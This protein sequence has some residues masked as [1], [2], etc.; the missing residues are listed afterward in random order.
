MNEPGF[1]AAG[2]GL[3]RGDEIELVIEKLIAGGDG[4]GRHERL[5]VFVPRTAPGDRARVR[6]AERKASYARAEVVEILAPGPGRRAAPCRHFGECG[7]CD[8]QHLEDERQIA[9]KVAATLE[10]LA[11]I[12][13]VE[14]PAHEVVGGAPWG[15][16]T[17]TRLH[18]S[19][20]SDGAPGE[21]ATLGY[22]GRRSHRI[23]AV[24][25][26]PVLVPELERAV[27]E[28]AATPP[29]HPPPRIDLA[30]GDGGE[31]SSAPVARGVPH[32]DVRVAVGP[33]AYAFDARCFFQGNR[34]LLER[35][36]EVAVGD[37]GGELAIDLYAGV[38]LFALPLA[39][40][41]ARVVAVEGDGVAARY[42]RINARRNG[43]GNV[44]VVH[45]AVE[46]WIPELPAACDR[47][48]VD[49][50]RPGLA[51]P[52]LRA[53]VERRPRTLTYVSC[54]P[55]ALARDLRELRTAY[56]IRA[57]TL[58]D[59]FPQTGHIEIVVQLTAMPDAA[60]GDPSP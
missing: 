29:A 24:E 8:L 55:A 50:P 25:E 60:A 32:G 54:H 14:L 41:Y 36:A 3:T 53:L 48:V 18:V 12:G 51:P 38:G 35:L 5:P 30:V 26:C 9:Y 56:E 4:L 22:H 39:S 6:V 52:I 20:P 27:L 40:R 19:P 44:E 28:L 45:R 49:P 59:L 10:T 47:V 58:L 33:F 23:V 57:L 43:T 15:Y 2:G 46:S 37:E 1:H 11:R 7:G 34:S 31:L 21:P 13:G 16:R 42:G 17:R